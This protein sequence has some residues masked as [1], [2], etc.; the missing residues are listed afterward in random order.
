MLSLLGQII[1]I[2]ILSIHKYVYSTCTFST[3][4]IPRGEAHFQPIYDDSNFG[5]NF[6][7]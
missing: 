2:V 5:Q 3:E 7:I 4:D 6:G 1:N